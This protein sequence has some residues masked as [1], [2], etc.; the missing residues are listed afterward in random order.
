MNIEAILVRLA[1]SVQDQLDR[2]YEVQSTLPPDSPLDQAGLRD[3][4]NIVNDYVDHSERGVAFEHLIYM[5]TE[6]DLVLATSELCDLASV[7]SQL[8]F[9]ES[10]WSR[11]RT[12]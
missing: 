12:A 3:G 2:L 7:G 9:T 1:R 5:I 4:F 11:I 6:S 8:G 10:L